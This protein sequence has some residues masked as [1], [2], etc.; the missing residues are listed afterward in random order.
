[1]RE[2]GHFIGGKP[3]AGTSGKFGDVFNPGRRRGHRPRRAGR[4]RGGRTRP[5]P[6][7]AA[8]WPAWAATPPLRRARV[9]FKLKELLERDR[10]ELSAIITAEHGKVLSDAD[11]EVQRGLEV[12][13]F[14]CGIP[15]LL[16]GEYTEAVGTGID[17][18]SIRQPL[19]VVAGITPFNF[20]LMVPLWM[21]PVALACGNCFILK[22]SEKDPSVSL[23]LAAL[24]KEAGLP[25]GVFR[26]CRARARR[27]RRS[28]RIP[29][30]P[31]SASSVRPRSPRRSIA[32][33]PRTASACRRWAGRRTTWW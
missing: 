22:P 31:R 33:A 28:W 16:K 27:S 3:V 18:W 12:V 20:P 25:D 29:T 14:A 9:M 30:S 26:W 7:P 2:I 11:G 8:A 23:K 24:L 6:P 21:I 15:H 5:S 13:E 17:A 10:K 19:G 1:M 4:C 32:A